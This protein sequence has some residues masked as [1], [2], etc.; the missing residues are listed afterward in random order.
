M[1]IF[2]Q[3]IDLVYPPRCSICEKFIWKNRAKKDQQELLFCKP[4]F[5][6]FS[7]IISPLCPT[8]GMPFAS[9]VEEDHLCEDCIRKRPFYDAARAPYLYEGG[10]MEA[11][12]QFKYAGKTHLA[13]SLGRLMTS[14][15]RKWVDKTHSYLMMPVPLHPKRLRERGF[16]QSLVLARYAAPLLGAELDFLSLRR[17]RYT[18]PQTGL[19]MTERGKNVRRAFDIMDR[20][21][22]KGRTILL[23][24][25]VTTTGNTLNE[26]ARM[27]KR[28]GSQEVLC[29]T[30]ARTSGQ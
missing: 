2:S 22:V 16:N 11:I 12:H 9:D 6:G 28:A 20:K 29:L 7:E 14:F 1:S 27:L 23:V 24:D 8:C 21:A 3:F 5:D 19:K 4:C 25:D 10:I 13:S 15:A 26:C 18:P 17:I 30:L